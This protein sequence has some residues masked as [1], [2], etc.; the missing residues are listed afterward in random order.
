MTGIV[1]SRTRIGIVLKVGLVARLSLVS[2]IVLAQATPP[3]A[4]PTSL[5]I[6]KG[7]VPQTIYR[8]FY[9]SPAGS[10]SNAGTE[11]A[12]FQT[13][14]KARDTVRTINASMS[15]DVVV[16]LRGGTYSLAGT[17]AFDSRDSG[18]NGFRVVY[19]AYPGEKPR[20]S[21]GQRIT[22][23]TSTSN[24]LYRASVG[25]LR[26]RQLYV[27][28]R[29][30]VRARTPNE[31][32][33]YQVRSWDT[34]GRRIQVA[35]DE[36]A[37]W[38]RLSQAEMVILGRGVNQS[39]LRIASL[40]A[41][42]TG[43]WVTAR[44]P[45][46]TRLFQQ[47][48][49]PKENYRPYYFENAMELLDAP[50]EWY[51]NT[52][53]S[54][55]FYRPRSGED[56]ATA[57][58]IAPRLERLLG[59]TGTLDS[60]V[61]NM[62]FRGLTFEH[63]TWLVPDSEGYVG[64]QASIVFTQP[65]PADQITWYP[66]H[67]LPAAVHVEAANLIRFERNEF[68]RL[69]ASALNLYRAVNDSTIIGNVIADVSGS[70]ISVDL[71]L[72]GNPADARVISRRDVVSNNY[73]LQTGRDY[74]QSVGIMAG[75]VDAIVVEHNELTDMPYSGISVGWGWADR[76]NA[77]RNN[78]V[79][80]NEIK[81]VLNLMADGGGIYTLSRQP[82]T[83]IA[84]NYVHDIVR[85]SVQGGFNLCGIYLDEGS[86]FITVRDNVLRN[87]GDLTIFQH[88]NGPSNTFTNNDGTSPAVITNAG[89]EPGFEDIRPPAP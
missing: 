33:Y 87:T 68:R 60:P 77:A 15:G 29:R 58:V 32:Q 22:S 35:A 52:D 72:E 9:V 62:E 6:L 61:R 65:L 48:Y 34:S 43:T 88:A 54:E 80:Y 27:N 86:N 21:G 5:R 13:V 4:A 3:P 75:Y 40:A 24:G 74:F 85:G 66:G 39:N 38:Q 37:N 69:G 76:D 16:Y 78:V 18:L 25:A 83:L 79:R 28:G 45:E 41:S 14:E 1:V 26:F 57:E 23:W 47:E 12:P 81:G 30:A 50:G 82:G 10:D 20:L 7:Q 11:A 51:L 36:V 89:L 63:T 31:G 55:V 17:V 64:D 8:T 71:N 84:E 67:R 42:G 70:G 53:T 49:P 44:D 73:V 56:M 46:R 59:V 2:A 19:R